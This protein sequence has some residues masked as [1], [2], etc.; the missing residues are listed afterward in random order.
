PAV[1]DRAHGRRG[2]PARRVLTRAK[3]EMTPHRLRILHLSDLHAEDPEKDAAALARSRVLGAGW[4][5]N[6]ARIAAAGPIDLVCLTGDVAHAGHDAD[7][8]A[9]TAFLDDLLSR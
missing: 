1:V 7:Y 3:K 6:L 8:A 4:A 2:G 9:A 5:E